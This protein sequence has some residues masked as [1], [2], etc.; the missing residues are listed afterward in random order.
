VALASLKALHG[1][2]CGNS[3]IALEATFLSEAEKTLSLGSGKDFANEQT[4]SVDPGLRI[5]PV[6]TDGFDWTPL[7]CWFGR[8][9]GWSDMG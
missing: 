3:A 5:G 6:L 9:I 8:A 1:R 2:N 4:G 7:V